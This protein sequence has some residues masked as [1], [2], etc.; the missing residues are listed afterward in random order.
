MF[1]KKIAVLSIPESSLLEICQHA[2][3]YTGEY[4]H[5]L[6]ESWKDYRV[7]FI[8]LRVDQAPEI[9]K[10]VFAKG[11]KGEIY[12]INPDPANKLQERYD[13]VISPN[14][15]NDFTKGDRNKRESL[16]E[17]ISNSIFLKLH[18]DERAKV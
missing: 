16:P 15:I 18:L 7:I 10:S 1:D 12:Y 17:Q 3:F 6:I 14:E 9:G 13:N 5:N 2:D 11:Y 8:D 4:S